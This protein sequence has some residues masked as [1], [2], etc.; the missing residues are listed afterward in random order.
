MLIAYWLKQLLQLI[1]ITRHRMYGTNEKVH[2]EHTVDTNGT[3]QFTV[4]SSAYCQLYN[5]KQKMKLILNIIF[6]IMLITTC[7][8]LELVE[9]NVPLDT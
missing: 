2:T 1:E 9:F 7:L 3:I 8:E 5:N 6:L 4:S